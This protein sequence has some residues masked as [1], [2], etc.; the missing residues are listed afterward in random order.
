MTTLHL[1]VNDVAYS[2]P[3]AKGAVTTGE[4]AEILEKK[5]HVMEVFFELYHDKIAEK[6]AASMA[7][8]IESIAQ[9]NPNVDLNSFDIGDIELMFQNYLSNNE[10]A[11]VSG[12]RIA[13]AEKGISHRKKGKKRGARSAFIDT[14]LYQTMFKSWMS[15]ML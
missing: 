4:V 11:M 3:E 5:Y 13:A 15:G 9:G 14:G 1:G 7:E 8:K 2:D 10:W 6:L 12:Q